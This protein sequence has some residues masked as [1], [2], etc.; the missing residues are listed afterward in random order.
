MESY[1]IEQIIQL[2]LSEDLS[3]KGD[4]TSNLLINSAQKG[5]AVIIA[6]E[7][8]IIAGLQVARQVFEKVDASTQFYCCIEEG[9]KVLVSDTVAKIEGPIQSILTAERTA[10]N[11][12]QRLSGI[13]TLTY[14]FVEKVKGT[15]AK[16]LDTRKTTPGLRSLEKYA[17]RI[18]GGMNHRSGLYDMV[19]IK[20][21]H[22]EA[23]GGLSVA[24]NRIREN[25]KAQNLNLKVE[26][27]ARNLEDV[28]AALN[29]KVDRIMLDNMNLAQIKKAVALVGGKE[30]LEVSGGVTLNTVRTI[31]ETGVDFISVGALIHSAKSMDLSLLL[32]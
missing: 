13:A 11:F 27:E 24:V 20:E 10:L 30:E 6:K 21:N 14:K 28:K 26:V 5:N 25:M 4:V 12:L 7:G 16:I 31:A 19:L 3:N 9:G 29:S 23:S 15:R 17:V 2:A 8:G 32:V 22:I 1:A 18:G